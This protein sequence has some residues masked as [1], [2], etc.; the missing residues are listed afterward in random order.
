MKVSEK[1]EGEGQAQD[2]L[3]V[4]KNHPGRGIV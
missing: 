2:D 1:P 3:K 4:I